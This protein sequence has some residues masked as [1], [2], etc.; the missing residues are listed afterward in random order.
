ERVAK[1]GKF[2]EWQMVILHDDVAFA[3]STEKFLWATWTRF[4]PASDIYAREVT[5]QNNHIGYGGP[6]VID[7]RMKPWYPDV[8]EPR[9][10]IVELVDRRWGEYFS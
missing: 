5:L 8:V 6:I 10:D 3:R 9:E 4:D 7:A 2:D 1:C